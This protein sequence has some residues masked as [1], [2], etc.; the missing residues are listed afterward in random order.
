[1]CTPLHHFATIS[2]VALDAHG[3]IKPRTCT[4]VLR[5]EV[6][7]PI[8]ERWVRCA[9]RNDQ[10]RVFVEFPMSVALYSPTIDKYRAAA[11][12][13]LRSMHQG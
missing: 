9:Q 11:A 8:Y 4:S 2:R 3:S 5:N 1:M 13:L 6:I 7:I 12:A 10:Y